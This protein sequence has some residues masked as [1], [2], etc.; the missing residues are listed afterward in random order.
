MATEHAQP[1]GVL[2]GNHPRR[3]YALAVLCSAFFMGVLDSTSVYTALPSIATDLRFAPG[4]LQWVVTGYGLAV[5]G[6]LLLG[7]RLAD[8]LGRR[9]VFLAAVAIFA[10]ASLLCG[11]AWSADVLVAARVVQ[12]AGAAVLT[13][14]GL[15][16]LMTIFPEGPDRNKALGVW[17]GLG[18]TGAT[19]GLLFGGIIT[20][21]LGWSWIFWVN[22]PACCVVLLVSPALLP[23]SRERGRSFDLA[24][25]LI[26]TSALV[27]VVFGLSRVPEAGWAAAQVVGPLGGALVLGA[28]FVLVERRAAAPLVPLR[29]FRSR[30]LVG[31]NVLVFIAG[32]AVDGILLVFTLYAHRI[33]GYSATQFGFA[34]AVMTLA[35]VVG[36]LGG[37]HLV[38]RAGFRRVGAT[39]IGLVAVGCLLLARLPVNGSFAGD[40]LG[41]L[42]I[43]GLG[44]GFAFVAAQIAALMGAP[45]AEAGLAAGLEET[46]FAIGTTLGVALASAVAVSRTAELTA[47]GYDRALAETGGLRL[48]L[49]VLTGIALLGV[50]AAVALLGKPQQDRAKRTLAVAGTA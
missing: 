43:F 35:S 27:L 16:I 45:E 12:G 10:A 29:I 23:E 31:G 18:G 24:G 46:S 8:M 40:L 22:I 19:A 38:T 6:L 1:G 36:A 25:A 34:M 42:L 3:W 47:A 14:A 37:Q 9:R 33:L 48:A 39:G 5:G 2:T 13:P 28:A 21:G 11:L 41:G 49:L 44:L 50:I 30:T 32:L 17:A 7:G 4:A 20:E 15:S 26:I